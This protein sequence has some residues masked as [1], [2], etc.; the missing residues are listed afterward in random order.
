MAGIFCIPLIGWLS[1]RVGLETVLWGVVLLPLL[2]FL[3]A[4]KL[5]RTAHG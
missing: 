3:M 4:L 1:D 2:G 5:P